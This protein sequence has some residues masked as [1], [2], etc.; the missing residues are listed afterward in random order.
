M[1]PIHLSGAEPHQ[2][3]EPGGHQPQ[4]GLT[5]EVL[6]RTKRRQYSDHLVVVELGRS[7]EAIEG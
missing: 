6:E 1:V 4:Q 2:P 5:D 3:V 7:D